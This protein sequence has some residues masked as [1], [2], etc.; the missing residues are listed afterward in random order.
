MITINYNYTKNGG[1]GEVEYKV[2]RQSDSAVIVNW[3]SLG[4]PTTDGAQSFQI[5]DT[6]LIN[7]TYRIYLRVD[8]KEDPNDYAVYTTVDVLVN[9][10][11]AGDG[12]YYSIVDKQG[13]II[14]APTSN[15]TTTWYAIAFDGTNYMMVGDDGYYSIVDKDGNIIKARTQNGS[16][17][18]RSIAFDGTNYMMV[19]QSGYYSIVDKDGNI[20]K[21]RTQNGNYY[22]YAIAGKVL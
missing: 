4:V 18:W 13:N 9:Y 15:G 17:S 5:D 12:G 14:K 19:G 22:W 21:A 8:K 20:I 3:T 7:D 1:Y 6:N 16:Y 2:V 11:M 10:M